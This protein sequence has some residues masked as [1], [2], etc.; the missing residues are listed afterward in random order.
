MPE[1][2]CKCERERE[3]EQKDNMK[4][5]AEHCSSDDESEEEEEEIVVPVP[6]IT[7]PTPKDQNLKQP[8]EQPQY[9]KQIEPK[10]IKEY[11]FP[12]EPPFKAYIGNLA[13]VITQ[14]EALEKEIKRLCWDRLQAS[15]NVLNCHV[16]QDR[17]TKQMRGFGYVEVETLDMVRTCRAIFISCSLEMT[18]QVVW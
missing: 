9:Q 16:A 3:R 6:V 11:I 8:Q 15:V 5:W 7:E 14:N 1:C 18:V 10:P 12:T 2:E 13:F 17:Q 4:S